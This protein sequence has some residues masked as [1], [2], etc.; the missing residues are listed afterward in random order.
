[1]TW[2]EFEAKYK[3]TMNKVTKED[4][5]VGD[6]FHYQIACHI[7]HHEKPYRMF[8]TFGSP[9]DGLT[10]E[11]VIRLA[12]L[13]LRLYDRSPCVLGDGYNGDQLH[14]VLTELKELKAE[15]LNKTSWNEDFYN[16]LKV[17]SN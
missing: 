9:L 6:Y 5:G 11:D 1:M 3:P 14:S 10:E 13:R 2:A 16:D 8:F 7:P 4:D 17:V 15:I 12:A